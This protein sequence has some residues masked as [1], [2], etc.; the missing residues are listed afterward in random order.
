M[1]LAGLLEMMQ[2]RSFEWKRREILLA[3][4]GSVLEFESCPEVVDFARLLLLR[5][6][7]WATTVGTQAAWLKDTTQSIKTL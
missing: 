2:N 6:V 3:D 7:T 4:V 5:P 1:I